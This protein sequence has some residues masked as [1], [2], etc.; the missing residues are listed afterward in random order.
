M[1]HGG[2]EW[3]RPQVGAWDGVALHLQSFLCP[4]YGQACPSFSQNPLYLPLPPR[5]RPWGS[6]LGFVGKKDY[7][8][9]SLLIS[10]PACTL[11][12][13]TRTLFPHHPELKDTVLGIDNGPSLTLVFWLLDWLLGRP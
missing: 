12:I 3:A 9:Q 11:P 1:S 6:W 10:A 8:D 7:P 13:F 5:I 2:Q 4:D